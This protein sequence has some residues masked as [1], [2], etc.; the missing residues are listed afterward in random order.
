MQP[1]HVWYAVYGANLLEERFRYYLEGGEIPDLGIR[2]VGA[3]NPAPPQA[4]RALL[5]PHRLRFAQQHRCWHGGVGFID[6]DSDA[7]VTTW[8]RAW[9]LTSEQ[10]EDVLRQE[11]RDQDLQIPWPEL[12][13]NGQV[14]CPSGWYR[15]LLLLEA[16]REGYPVIAATAPG[17]EQPRPPGAD[18][19]GTVIAGLV[20]TYHLGKKG[21]VDYLAAVPG[22]RPKWSKGALGRMWQ[23]VVTAFGEEQDIEQ[24]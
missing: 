22:I 6:S 9:L 1:E 20:E 13:A 8:G 21:L 4:D 18:Y 15:R 11:N 16:D 19:L 2:Q 17:K 23:E 5:L 7:T 10:C 12:L 3:R 24:N 14:D